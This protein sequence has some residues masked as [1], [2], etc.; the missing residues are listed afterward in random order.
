VASAR[1]TDTGAVDPLNEIAAIAKKHKLW[2]HI[3]AAYGGFF[4]RSNIINSLTV[5]FPMS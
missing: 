1:T 2:F 5:S 3:D 4:I